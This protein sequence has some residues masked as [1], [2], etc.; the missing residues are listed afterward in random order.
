MLTQHRLWGVGWGTYSFPRVQPYMAFWGST[1]SFS[2]RPLSRY[3]WLFLCL[4][5]YHWPAVHCKTIH[6]SFA[7][8]YFSFLILSPF[9]RSFLFLSSSSSLKSYQNNNPKL[10]NYKDRDFITTKKFS[11][12]RFCNFPPQYSLGCINAITHENARLPPMWPGFDSR[13]RRHKRV[14]FVDSLLNSDMFFF[15]VLRFSPLPKHQDLIWFD[16]R[17]IWFSRPN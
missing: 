4:P 15:R 16:L 14:E 13:T 1:C 12:T 9:L 11:L 3:H 17:L 8:A 5:W 2:D 6:E 7:L 10:W